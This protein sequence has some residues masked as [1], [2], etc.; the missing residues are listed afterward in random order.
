MK[1]AKNM[2]ALEL[3]TL[4]LSSKPEVMGDWLYAD[5]HDYC[6]NLSNSERRKYNLHISLPLFDLLLLY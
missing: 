4:R 3:L 6:A 2:E 1:H 5:S